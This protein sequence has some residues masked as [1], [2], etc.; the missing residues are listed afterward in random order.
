MGQLLRPVEPSQHPLVTDNYRAAT[1]ALEA[2]YELIESN[3]C[4]VISCALNSGEAF[5]PVSITLRP[6]AL[7]T[8]QGAPA[9]HAASY[10]YGH[11]FDHRRKR[12]V[13][14]RCERQGG[15]SR[16]AAEVGRN[17]QPPH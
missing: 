11:Y 4:S 12:H 13:V 15:A 8:Q 14:D 3:A 10:A 2:F 7:S 5:I 17:H 1:P 6:A 16:N 9:C